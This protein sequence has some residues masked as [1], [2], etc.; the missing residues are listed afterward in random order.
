M[1]AAVDDKKEVLFDPSP[2]QIEFINA[3]FS[4]KYT[5]ILFG[6]AI[7]GGKTYAGLGALL[8][9]C[10]FFPGSIWA[11]VRD[12]LPTLKRTTIKSFLKICPKRFIK[13][14]NQETQTVTFTNGSQIIFFPENYDDDKE[15]DRWKGLEVNGFLLEECNEL[16]E[17]S[18]WKAIE[19]AGSYIPPG[20]RKKPKPLV[21]MTC[22]P[23][24]N[25]V[26]ELFY[27]RWKNG[28]LPEGW[29]YIPSKITD[30][31]YVTADQDYMNSLKD[32]PTFQ[33]EV[34]VNGN[35]D[36]QLKVGG[37]YFKYFEL[38]KHVVQNEPDAN[39]ALPLYDPSLPIHVSWDDNVNPYLPCGLFQVHTTMSIGSD[40][41]LKD[42]RVVMIDEIAAKSPDNNVEKVCKEI[43]RR[44]PGH[45]AGTYVYGDATAKKEDTKL[46]KGHN[47]Y[48][49]ILGHLKS[50]HPQSR[51]MEHNP[52]VVP[53]AMWMNSV[54]EKNVGRIKMEIGSNC[55]TAINDFILLKEDEN[56]GKNKV[57]QKNPKTGVTEQIV[58][59]FADLLEYFMVSCFS[60]QFADYQAGGAV[61]SIRV[62]KNA[63]SKNSY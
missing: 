14:Y 36:I 3:V 7:R 55:K 15:L 28:L 45:T 32:L 6:G 18:F 39:G 1:D 53:R 37:E 13:L 57:K 52:N 40:G 10:K 60:K 25:W 44:Y 58:G 34:F 49:L 48:T 2:K 23:A 30:N 38:D 35:W 9:L 43:I 59:H 56:G 17:V 12:S 31:P 8:L 22:N 54:F 4:S 47:F 42:Y 24:N 41:K 27:N 63:H 33:Y 5:K 50:H 29:L 21:M 11:V 61:S 20:G 62:G 26:K 19:R 16:Q 46:E 51:V